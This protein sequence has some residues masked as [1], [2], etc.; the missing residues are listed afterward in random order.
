[1]NTSD[2]LNRLTYHRRS[3]ATLLKHL[4][5]EE[6]KLGE[7]V[8]GCGTWLHI[9]EW[10]QTGQAR[11]RNANFCKKFLLC[12]SCGARRAAKMV[13][14]YK[15]KVETV[16]QAM[17]HLIPAMVTLTIKNRDDLADGLGH[18]KDSWTRMMTAKRLGKSA[19]CRNGAVEWNK[20][21]GSIR[22][23]E[24]TRKDKGWHPHIHAFVLLEEYIS[25][26]MLSKE[27][28]RF[29]GDSFVV[30]IKR[31]DNGIVPGLIET[32]KYV[33]KLA[34]LTP[35]NALEVYRVAK[36]SRF[37]DPQGVLRGVAEPDI[38]DDDEDENCVGP[39]RD[40]M[41]LWGFRSESYHFRDYADPTQ[42]VIVKPG[43]AGFDD[44]PP[45]TGPTRL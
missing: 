35:E 8:E 13:S 21:Q 28:E 17:P 5:S 43:D 14:A 25:H 41:A 24:V 4:K 22:A 10:L 40:F 34:D 37:T 19:N 16:L 18:L 3:Q 42:L 29:T 33:S 27:W 12:Q 23:I 44:L 38:C 2:V 7:K 39:Y 15:P 32:L 9:R 36:G 6:P 1:M 30:G 45:A 31:C 26:E 11:I 20:V